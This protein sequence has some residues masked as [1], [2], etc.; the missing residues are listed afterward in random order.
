VWSDPGVKRLVEFPPLPVDE[1]VERGLEALGHAVR[2]GRRRTGLSQAALQA[3]SGVSQSVISRLERGV[4]G[5]LRLPRLARLI[6][7]LDGLD[8]E[9][10]PPRGRAP[11]ELG[12][13][14]HDEE[15]W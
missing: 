4:L 1:R 3:R 2:E 14:M 11:V 9:P 10:L 5:G 6:D 15:E 13:D 7:A 8:I 12:D